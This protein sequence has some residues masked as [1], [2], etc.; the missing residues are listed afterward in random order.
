MIDGFEEQT[1]SLT[2]YEKNKLLPRVVEELS[3]N[4]GE[5]NVVSS[6]QII[7]LL[8][9]EGHKVSPPRF[10]KVINYI[11]VNRIIKRLMATSKGYYIEMDDNKYGKYLKSLESRIEAISAV[12][13]AGYKDLTE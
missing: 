3:R 5:N 4:V 13:K 6:N 7:S 9:S 8:K 11:R 12:Y 1:H 10:R 2:S